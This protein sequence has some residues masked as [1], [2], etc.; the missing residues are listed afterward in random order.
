MVSLSRNMDRLRRVGRRE[1][2]W[3]SNNDE[4]RTTKSCASRCERVRILLFGF[5]SA[6]D[7]R[8][9]SFSLFRFQ[10]DVTAAA[11]AVDAYQNL[12]VRFQVLANCNQILRISN[13]LLVDLL[14][15]VALA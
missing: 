9:S 13:R 11:L 1:Y 10:R 6:F 15:D 4:A 2:F 14:D 5:P 3:I 12:L 8:A 7:I